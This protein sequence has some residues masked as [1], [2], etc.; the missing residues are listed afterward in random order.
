[1]KFCLRYIL[2][3]LIFNLAGSY[4]YSQI[5]YGGK[6]I[7]TSDDLNQI[8]YLNITDKFD[9]NYQVLNETDPLSK[10]MRFAQMLEVNIDIRKSGFS[11]KTNNGTI[12]LTGIISGSAF[13]LYP[14]FSNY[15]LKKG[16]SLFIYNPGKNDVHGKFTSDN[17]NPGKI[18][19]IMPVKGDTLIIEYFEPDE[20]NGDP[21]ILGEIGHD[22]IGIYKNLELRDGNYGESG[23]CN[24]DINCFQGE[25][26]QREK[27][28][29][30]RTIANGSLCSGTL[31][32]NTNQDAR[33]YFLSA[34]HCIN[35]QTL[36]DAMLVVFNYESPGCNG[37][38]GSVEQSLSGGM[39]RSTTHHIDFSLIELY[40]SP[41]P[42]YN[43]IFAGW[44]T[45][46]EIEGP[47]I[48][49]HHP[50]GDVKKISTDYDSP[51]T[52]NYG[53]GY[54]FNTHWLISSWES[55][56]TEGG[57]SGSPLFDKYH[58]VVGNL[59]GGEA[60]CNNSINDYYSKFTEAWDTYLNTDDQLKYWL[61]PI[62]TGQ[63]TINAY[64]PYFGLNPP[65]AEFTSDRNNILAGSTIDFTDLSNGNVSSWDWS[66]TGATPSQSTEQH[67]QNIK[68]T[69]GG[70][71][72]VTLVINNNYGSNQ[73]IKENFITVDVGCGRFSNIADDELLYLYTFSGSE[74][75][76]WTG[77]NQLG[78][79]SYAES[80]TNQSGNYIHG[81]YI[82]PAKAY[83]GSIGSQIDINI[84]SGGGKPGS[85]LRSVQYE[86][87]AFTPGVWKYIPF[88][89]AV[90]TDG[91]FYAGFNIYYTQSDT[92]AVPSAEPRGPGGLNTTFVKKDGQWS[93]INDYS[94][95]M[96]TSLCI[97]PYI[98]GTIS[99][100]NE[101]NPKSPLAIFPNPSSGII[102]AIIDNLS[103]EKL[104]RIYNSE[105]KLVYTTTSSN[106][107][108]QI[109]LDLSFLPDGI[110][111]FQS[112]SDKY[113]SCAK[114]QII[115]N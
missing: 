105:G 99:S 51:V 38:D 41:L 62:G 68:Y 67:P 54:D 112:E 103:E 72:K 98:C 26:W 114:F 87:S 82:L 96:T 71:F 106:L 18:L 35:S 29:V 33:P 102:K 107:S 28:S 94:V 110:Y 108:G 50:Q 7:S 10:V 34:N 113:H 65:Q 79:S 69:Y 20:F 60:D 1:M 80:Y 97:E 100:I 19:A 81:L 32:N 44:N 23:E 4:S 83:S 14:V 73:I 84:W 63:T 47:V 74:W 22:Y 57:S 49:I 101:N 52:A 95:E 27:R 43:P 48:S 86:I 53:G 78:F 91:S 45:S 111:L 17:N 109:T 90:E 25:N 59:T 5:N 76:Y 70:T 13:S 24:V 75:G 2:A 93:P 46:E 85:I 61:D 8:P 42:S 77:H 31:I 92:F 37:I 12:F 36:A 115:K 58:R 21:L 6:P 40:D 30:C 66:F 39:L 11:R 3:V 56:T 9:K 55:G 64:D 88:E 104:I 15:S 89:P 16:A